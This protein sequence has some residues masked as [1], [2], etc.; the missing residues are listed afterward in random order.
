MRETYRFEGSPGTAAGFVDAQ[1][2]TK[3]AAGQMRFQH[4]V[5]VAGSKARRN[6]SPGALPARK[7]S[8]M[9]RHPASRGRPGRMISDSG[10]GVDQPRTPVKCVRVTVAFPEPS[11]RPRHGAFSPLH[12]HDGP[13]FRQAFDDNDV[14]GRY[15][16]LRRIDLENLAIISQRK[17]SATLRSCH[18]FT[19]R[20]LGSWSAF[21]STGLTCR[22]VYR[23]E[24]PPHPDPGSS[25][26]QAPLPPREREKKAL[27]MLKFRPF[28]SAGP[29]PPAWGR[30]C[31][32]LVEGAREGGKH[33]LAD[34][35]LTEVLQSGLPIVE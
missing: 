22:G 12:R 32:E 2:G 23:L 21:G 19:L 26:G 28:S 5:T 30:A 3:W 8:S 4:R 35:F 31:P 13:T 1:G 14:W 27:S 9:R 20:F 6:R 10:R 17:M 16:V 34:I 29:L 15:F 25:P 7:S 33:G 24:I 18:G 11:E